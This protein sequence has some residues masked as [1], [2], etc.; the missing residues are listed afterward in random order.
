[1]AE[2]T[3]AEVAKLA[4]LSRLTF[5]TSAQEDMRKDLANILDFVAKLQEVDTSRVTPMTSSVASTNTPERKDEPEEVGA[6]WRDSQQKCS[7]AA[8]MGF[9]VV[10]KVIE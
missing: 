3:N 4:E 7:P 5:S 9:F 6:T 1:M 8:D 10:P 2:I